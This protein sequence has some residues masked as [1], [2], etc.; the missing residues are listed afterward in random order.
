MDYE[1]L[2]MTKTMD[3]IQKC[4]YYFDFKYM[5]KNVDITLT[6]DTKKNYSDYEI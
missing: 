1:N 3:Y 4:K 2:G 6:V 5:K